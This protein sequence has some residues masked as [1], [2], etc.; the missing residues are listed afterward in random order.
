M[1]SRAAPAL[2]ARRAVRVAAEQPKARVT[3]EYREGDDSVT[4]H[5]PPFQ[6]HFVMCVR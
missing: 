6:T 2:S 4:G 3:K 5:T 1:A